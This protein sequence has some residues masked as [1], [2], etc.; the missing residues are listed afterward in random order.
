MYR[1]LHGCIGGIGDGPH[2]ELLKDLLQLGIDPSEAGTQLFSS[3]LKPCDQVWESPLGPYYPPI[4]IEDP[5]Y[6]EA[7][8]LLAHA[9]PGS[10]SFQAISGIGI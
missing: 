6:I 1:I 8:T 3:W 7:V 2:I 4:I 10:P 5:F 9:D